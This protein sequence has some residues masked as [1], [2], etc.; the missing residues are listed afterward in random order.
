MKIGSKLVELASLR[1]KAQ[2]ILRAAVFVHKTNI[3]AKSFWKK[4]GFETV[5]FIETYG[6][7]I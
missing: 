7:D 2:G 1:L 6:M 3:A 5:D 4:V